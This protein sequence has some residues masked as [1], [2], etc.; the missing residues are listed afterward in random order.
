MTSDPPIHEDYRPQSFSEFVGNQRTVAAIAA[1][2]K[3]RA[4]QTFLLVGEPG[5][6][7]TSMARAIAHELGVDPDKGNYIERNA[8]VHNG[9]D[10]MRD[11]ARQAQYAPL[12]SPTRVI[13]LDECHTLSAQAWQALLKPLEEPGRQNFWVLCTTELRKVPKNVQSRCQTFELKKVPQQLLAEHLAEA[14]EFYDGKTPDSV[15]DAIAKQADGSVR[16][17]L[18]LLERVLHIGNEK[19][20]LE[21]LAEVQEDEGPP[22][23]V[24]FCRAL[25]TRDIRKI[26]ST[27]KACRAVGG[28]GLRRVVCAYFTNVWFGKVTFGEVLAAFED[29]YET[30]GIHHV[31]VSIQVLRDS[32]Y[33]K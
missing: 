26:S 2:V 10:T 14:C 30:D 24:E 31:I 15:I 3:K 33:F 1:L 8:A 27:L 22:E 13:V 20:A 6:G 19:K 25:M 18:M 21:L 17:G 23:A 28:E 7:K 16:A 5:T 4:A 29:P 32:G 9:I 11:L 12:G